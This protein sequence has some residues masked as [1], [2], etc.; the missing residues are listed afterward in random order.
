MAD[1]YTGNKRVRGKWMVEEREFYI[2]RIAEGS[3]C[4]SVLCQGI[5]YFGKLI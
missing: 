4:V 1:Q 5:K 2:I 3:A